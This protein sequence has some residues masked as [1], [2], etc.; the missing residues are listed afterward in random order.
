MLLAGAQDQIQFPIPVLLV[1]LL[2]SVVTDVVRVQKL[3]RQELQ[4]PEA[5]AVEVATLMPVEMEVLAL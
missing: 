3:L 4:V 1:D 2:A 5:V